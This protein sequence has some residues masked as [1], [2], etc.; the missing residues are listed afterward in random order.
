MSNKVKIKE[1]RGTIFLPT[2]SFDKKLCDRLSVY[3]NEFIPVLSF[4]MM[5]GNLRI[6]QQGGWAMTSLDFKHKL[7]FLDGKIDYTYIFEP[8]QGNHDAFNSF[9]NTCANIFKVIMDYTQNNITRIAIAP[10]FIVKEDGEKVKNIIRDYFEI[11]RF[12]DRPVDSCDFNQVYRTI[13]NINGLD[14]TINYVSKFRV[15]QIQTVTDGNVT[16]EDSM[17]ID[18]D[19][20]TYPNPKI[21]FDNTFADDFCKK[22]DDMC[23]EFMKFYSLSYE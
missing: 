20:N 19:I 5:I 6:E 1:L 10:S 18:F 11:N 8:N 14:V 23:N 7:S 22:S 3:L 17:V 2:I 16:I 21:K 15:E 12:K 9:L 4:P 13:E